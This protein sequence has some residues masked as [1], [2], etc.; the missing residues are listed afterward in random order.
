MGEMGE[1]WRTSSDS[2]AGPMQ[3]STALSQLMTDDVQQA[4]EEDR[5][6]LNEVQKGMTNKTS[7][8]IDLPI[9]AGQLRFRRQLQAMINEEEQVD[10]QMAQ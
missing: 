5:N 7:P 3:S 8:H 6:V 1:I 2:T 4:F 9:D 10:K